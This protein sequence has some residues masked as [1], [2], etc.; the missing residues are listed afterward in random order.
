[1]TT[2][3]KVWARSF[4]RKTGVPTASERTEIIDTKT[5]ELFNGAKTIVDVKNAYESFW[6]ELDPMTKDI[7]F[8]SQVA[9]V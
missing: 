1:M 2:K 6:N 5:N 9:V 4:D 3:Y 7:V 8:V